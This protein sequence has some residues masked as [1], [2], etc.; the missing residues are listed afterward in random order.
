MLRHQV[1]LGRDWLVFWRGCLAVFS[2]QQVPRI[3]HAV[4]ID[5]AKV[6]YGLTTFSVFLGDH[7]A[8]ERG[9]PSVV[10]PLEG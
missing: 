1:F 6:S 3:D 4:A 9:K 5:I 7:N 2:S 8:M 10:R